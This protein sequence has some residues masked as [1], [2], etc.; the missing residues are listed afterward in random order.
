MT[1]DQASPAGSRTV[2]TGRTTAWSMVAS[3]SLLAVLLIVGAATGDRSERGATGVWTIVAGLVAVGVLANVLTASSVRVS[4][5]SNGLHIRWGVIGW[6]RS[7]YP[8]AEVALAEVVDVPWYRVTWGFWWT[9][10]RTSCTVRSGP[11][12]R[13]TLTTGRIVTVTV[14]DPA[15]AVRALDEAR[16][17]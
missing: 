8:L 15:R 14:P 12:L 7:R 1:T 6:P 5:G 10:T 3:T 9:P 13:L 16:T 2:Y 4:A 11:T 17:A